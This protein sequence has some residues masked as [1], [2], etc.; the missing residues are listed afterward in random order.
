YIAKMRLNRKM[1]TVDDADVEL[2]I[3]N[4]FSIAKILGMKMFDYGQQAAQKGNGE[5]QTEFCTRQ[6]K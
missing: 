4:M 5:E 6:S 2:I 3:Q 1:H